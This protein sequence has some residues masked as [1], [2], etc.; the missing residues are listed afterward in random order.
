MSG[1]LRFKRPAQIVE[2]YVQLIRICGLEA[3]PAY[4]DSLIVTTTS[5][6]IWSFLR[7]YFQPPHD[8]LTAPKPRDLSA[9]KH[10]IRRLDLKTLRRGKDIGSITDQQIDLAM[11]SCGEVPA[12]RG[13]TCQDFATIRGFVHVSKDPPLSLSALSR[14]TPNIEDGAVVP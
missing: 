6:P 9:K 13:T 12:Q 3:V 14:T 5:N 10:T 11:S 1:S 4:L 8:P 2:F 7:G